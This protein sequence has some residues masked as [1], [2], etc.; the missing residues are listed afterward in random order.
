MK[1]RSG[2]RV[3]GGDLIVHWAFRTRNA[4]GALECGFIGM[5]WVTDD[6]T[7]VCGPAK[8]TD[9]GAPHSKGVAQALLAGPVFPSGLSWQVFTTMRVT[10]EKKYRPGCCD[11][12][13]NREKRSPRRSL[14]S[15][16]DRRGGCG[17]P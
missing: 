1:G 9:G 11:G 5:E 10:W 3:A 12:A 7:K 15:K 8:A 2:S 16:R 17:L 4:S 13:H 6:F 14:L